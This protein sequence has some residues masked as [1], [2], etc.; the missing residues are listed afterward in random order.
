LRAN[1]KTVKF[2]DQSVEGA[3]QMMDNLSQTYAELLDGI[4]DCPDRIVLNAYFRAGHIPGGFRLWWRDLYGSDDKLD[5][6]HLMRM[7]GRFSRRVRA[8]G[9]KHS[10]PVI[11]CK[12][13]TRKHQLAQ[14]YMPPDP[15]YKGLF[16]VLVA[17]ASAPAWHVQKTKEGRIQTLV[18]KYPYVNH[19]HFHIIDPDWGHVTVRMS[20]HPPFGAQVILNGHE[21]VSRQATKQGMHFTKEGNCFTNIIGRTDGCQSTDASRCENAIGSLAIGGE[22]P[23][24]TQLA[25]ALCSQNIVGPLRQVCDRWLYSACLHFGLSLEE[26]KQTR[27]EYDYSIFQVETSRNFLFQ[28]GCQ[29]EQCFQGL[30]DRTRTHLDIERLKTIFG[31]KRRPFWP[32]DKTKQPPREEIVIERPQHD[33]TIFKIHFGKLTVKLYS[34]GARVLR[35]EAIIHNTKALK[36]KRSLP[37]F[38]VIVTQLKQI[39]IRFLNQ[40]QT[41]NTPFIADDTLD[42]LPEPTL[43]GKSKVAGI[44]LNKS[45]I[46]AVLEAVVA[47][48]VSPT[49]FTASDLAAKV[50]AIQGLSPT[51]YLPRHAAY[52]LKKLRGKQWVKKIGKSRRYETVPAGLQTMTALVVL[53]DQVIKPVL[54][55]AGKPTRGPRPK[56]ENKVD[57][58]YRVIQADMRSLFH[59]LGVMV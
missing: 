7:A 21:Y 35:S 57:K 13:E 29:L 1:N 43:V 2:L 59:L 28:R 18:R 10:I 5:D 15:E 52:D 20:G 25:D 47:L 23:R 32:Q 34:K 3:K 46:R 27:F 11:D 30:I 9:Q 51:E 40:L 42:V 36:G 24:L 45:R 8:Y 54:A 14:E 50:C 48:S 12:S 58:Q 56:Q 37:A 53:R 38:P 49:G 39:L 55:G 17:R 19:Y 31:L 33:L 4:Y 26:Q 16:L 41:I 6:E 22:T 44:D